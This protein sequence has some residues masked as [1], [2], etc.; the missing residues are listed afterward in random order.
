MNLAVRYGAITV[1]PVREVDAIEARP[2]NPPR[3]LTAA[4]VTL[5]QKS[6][7]A[8]EQPVEA[9]LPDL[10]TFM[11]GTGVRIGEALAVLWHQIDLDA[12]TVEITHSIA[13]PPREGLIRNLSQIRN[14]RGRTAVGCPPDG[15]LPFA[16]KPVQC[17]QSVERR[18]PELTAHGNS[19]THRRVG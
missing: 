16:S 19:R 10:V 14:P 3:A 9:D 6:L 18:R 8:D 7:T 4:E 2:K 15:A 1:N 11:L 13:R 5:L 12:G 17:P